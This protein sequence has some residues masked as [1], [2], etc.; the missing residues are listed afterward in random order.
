MLGFH[1]EARL[2]MSVRPSALVTVAEALAAHREV[3]FAAVT[4]GPTNL[5]VAVVC[6]MVACGDRV[7]G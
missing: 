2:W 6:R 7:Q 5:V 3:S 4:T 1:V